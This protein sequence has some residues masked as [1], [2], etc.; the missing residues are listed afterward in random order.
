LREGIRIG[1]H[2][3]FGVPNSEAY[4]PDPSAVANLLRRWLSWHS[5]LPRP[6]SWIPSNLRPKR[7]LAL[8]PASRCTAYDL[9]FVALADE[10]DVK[11]VTNDRELRAAF[12]DRAISP[13]A[14]VS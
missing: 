12:P 2:L 11:L 3:G 13:A 4:L 5:K 1:L 14:F 6:P 10:L 8:V 7:I 9:E